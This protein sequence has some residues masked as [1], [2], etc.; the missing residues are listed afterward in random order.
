MVPIGFHTFVSDDDKK[1]LPIASRVSASPGGG[2]EVDRRSPQMSSKQ[3]YQ[4]RI[5]RTAESP[6]TS[7]EDESALPV[8][9]LIQPTPEDDGSESDGLPPVAQIYQQAVPS[10]NISSFSSNRQNNKIKN[11]YSKK[12]KRCAKFAS[13]SRQSPSRESATA[14][15]EMLLRLGECIV[16]DWTDEGYDALF[17]GS[18]MED[19]DRPSRGHPTWEETPTHY[20]PEL[21]EKRKQ[22]A[23]RRKTGFSLGDCLD[24]FG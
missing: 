16:L 12:D 21:V 9:P 22:R 17:G 7:D 8:A 6:P 13:S 1:F 24:E 18:P 23:N 15:D 20:D 3:A 14:S 4:Q 10:H 2:M 11:T 19:E 5:N